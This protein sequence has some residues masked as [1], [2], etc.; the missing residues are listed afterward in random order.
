MDCDKATDLMMK[1]MDGV[2]SEAEA[3]SL[4]GHIT[5]CAQCKED[6]LAYDGI[7]GNFS[8]MTLCEPPEGFEL[9]VMS[10]IRQ[11]PEMG[12]KSVHR[13]LYGV[14]GVFSFLLGLGIILD[15]NK[16]AALDWMG[17]YPQFKPLLDVYAPVS[18][19]V[20]NISHQ[21]SL[22]L[23]MVSSYLQQVSSG[24]YYV[25]LLIFGVL[26]AAQFII[27]RKERVA[28]K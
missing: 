18:E 3:A 22:A 28:G 23:S 12:L 2:L 27:Y 10:I 6:F 26:A 20:R 8:G 15:M 14:L 19:A 25:P 4:N 16:D 5:E 24:L 11:L 21:V 13:S 17:R 9:R 7:M 1:Y